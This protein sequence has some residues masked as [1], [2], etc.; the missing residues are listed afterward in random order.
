MRGVSE[1]RE[2]S[3]RAGRKGRDQAE[4]VTGETRCDLNSKLSGTG[5][6]SEKEVCLGFRITRRTA[7]LGCRNKKINQFYIV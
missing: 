4:T 2:E 5:T 6:I 7:E 1:V 3:G